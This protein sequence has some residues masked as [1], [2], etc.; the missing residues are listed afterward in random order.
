M[1]KILF[2]CVLHGIAFS[3][4][5][6]L[7]P[8]AVGVLWYVATYLPQKKAAEREEAQV[9]DDW[10]DHSDLDH[11]RLTVDFEEMAYR[12]VTSAPGEP[13]EIEEGVVERRGEGQWRQRMHG[14]SA[15]KALARYRSQK[16]ANVFY[17]E[18]TERRLQEN[19]WQALDGHLAS[20]LEVAYQ[21]YLKTL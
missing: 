19:A 18:E 4:A 15:R 3:V 12:R 20:R 7:G 11:S 9:F 14:E 21:R 16:K 5:G 8:L 17:S 6:P 10:T 1:G 13:D 2:W